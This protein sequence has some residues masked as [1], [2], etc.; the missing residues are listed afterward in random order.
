M[1]N[2]ARGLSSE[3]SPGSPKKFPQRLVLG[4][5]GSDPDA[6]GGR[7]H[8]VLNPLRRALAEPLVLVREHVAIR[9]RVGELD[10]MHE[11]V[12]EIRLEACPFRLAK[13][14]AETACAPTCSPLAPVDGLHARRA[15]R[16]PAR[17]RSRRFP[18]A[19]PLVPPCVRQR[20]SP[21][22]G[23]QLRPDLRL[24]RPS[25]AC[26]PWRRRW[27]RSRSWYQIRILPAAGPASASTND[28]SSRTAAV[29]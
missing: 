19:H 20:L 27:P 18:P 10:Q 15:A 23:R 3:T 6:V 28:Q 8:V 16:P 17:Y 1:S 25:S 11:L 12:G 13:Q 5:V 7:R 2:P 29:D 14:N 9:Q 22:Q 24:H 21:H 26:S 4:L